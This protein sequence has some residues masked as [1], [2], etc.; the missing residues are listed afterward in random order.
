[1]LASTED[2][3][4]EISKVTQKSKIFVKNR[5]VSAYVIHSNALG[6]A[7]CKG[8]VN[9]PGIYYDPVKEQAYTE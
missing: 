1:M 4:E 7:F 3:I 5:E 9:M 8:K 6:L 2:R